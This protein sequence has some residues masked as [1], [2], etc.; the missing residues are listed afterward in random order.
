MVFQ[1]KPVQAD[2]QLSSGSGSPLT[3]QLPD[4]PAP[5]VAEAAALPRLHIAAQTADLQA[6]HDLLAP[7]DGTAPQATATDRDPQGI[8]ALH[9]ASINNHVLASKFLLESGAEV[10][11]IGGDLSATPLHWAARY[12]LLNQLGQCS[13]FR[14]DTRRTTSSDRGVS[15]PSGRRTERAPSAA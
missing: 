5:A 1:P 6:L 13:P 11:A 14:H 12:V 7:T 3:D 2:T 10:D 8:T 4:E 9:W 15:T